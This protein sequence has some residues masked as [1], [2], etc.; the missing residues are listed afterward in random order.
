MNKKYETFGKKTRSVI[1]LNL[2]ESITTRLLEDGIR[3][4]QDLTDHKH[5]IPE[6]GQQNYQNAV[7][8]QSLYSILE[9]IKEPTKL[10][11]GDQQIDLMFGTAGIRDSSIIEIC[12]AAKNGKT[13]LCLVVGILLLAAN[14]CT[15][16]KKLGM[17][18]IDTQ[19]GVSGLNIASIAHMLNKRTYDNNQK[20]AI[21]ETLNAIQ[22]IRTA[23]LFELMAVLY[24]LS[25]LSNS[26]IGVVVI[27][28]PNTLSWES[29]S[30][31]R[32]VAT[33][34][35]QVSVKMNIPVLLTNITSPPVFEKSQS[36]G[37]I[38]NSITTTSQTAGLSMHVR[39]ER[40]WDRIISDRIIITNFSA[41]VQSFEDSDIT[42]SN[43]FDSSKSK[44]FCITLKTVLS[45]SGY[46][47]NVSN[48]HNEQKFIF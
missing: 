3:S 48:A 15:N 44:V 25:E 14:R 38:P 35:K 17:L 36:K 41:P 26:D 37:I 1:S 40:L 27:D 16:N 10:T 13:L 8:V 30:A 43:D 28:N 4:V 32:Q 11:T 21:K 9:N 12:G 18:Y 5:Q 19:G 33:L 42:Q 47:R 20:S 45:V 34:V 23:T 39:N 7:Q 31:Q 29:V 46:S 6:Y 24:Q 22:V 2:N